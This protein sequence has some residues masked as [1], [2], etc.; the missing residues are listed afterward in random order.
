[1]CRQNNKIDWVGHAFDFLRTIIS[2][3]M[4]NYGSLDPAAGTLRV[5]TTTDSP[6]WETA[7][8]GFGACMQK[9]SFFNFDPSVNGGR[10]FFRSD[11]LSARRFRD[12]DIYSECFRLLETM[13]HAAV[14]VPTGDGRLVWFAAER[15][16]TTD[17]DEQDRVLLLLGQEHLVNSQRLAMA[18]QNLR[19]QA[20]HNATTFVRAGFTPRE[21]EVACWLVEGKTNVEIATLLRVKTQTVKGYV[22]SMFN[23]TGIGNRLALSIQLLE[24]LQLASASPTKLQDFPLSQ[25]PPTPCPR[26]PVS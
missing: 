24:I 2:A 16:G 22:T 6:Q 11:F 13:D 12:T 4:I 25:I 10:P 21:A 8:Q 26:Q 19:G 1:M 3:D 14:H 17:F 15:G 7:V 23:K 9:Y 5:G 20:L 18:R